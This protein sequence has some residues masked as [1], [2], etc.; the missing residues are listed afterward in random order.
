MEM[1]EKV[2]SSPSTKFV[3]PMELT[4][5]AQNFVSTMG[6]GAGAALTNGVDGIDVREG[7]A[8]AE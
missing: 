4:S 1:L 8:L 2:G 7:E 5:I 6:A 3:L